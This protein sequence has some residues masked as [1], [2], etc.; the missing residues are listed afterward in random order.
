[1]KRPPL[2]IFD[3]QAASPS[4]SVCFAGAEKFSQHPRA[5]AEFAQ[6]ERICTLGQT[7]IRHTMLVIAAAARTSIAFCDLGLRN[8][9]AQ[10]SCRSVTASWQA[11]N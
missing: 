11:L 7:T 9:F 2:D 1:V 6:A 8:F 3:S 10:L 4:Q 5:A